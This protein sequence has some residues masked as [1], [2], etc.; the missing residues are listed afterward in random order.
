MLSI[1]SARRCS[2]GI[3][4]VDDAGGD[5]FGAIFADLKPSIR[6]FTQIKIPLSAILL[7]LFIL[8]AIIIL[9]AL[10][11]PL[12]TELEKVIIVQAAMPCAVFPIVLAQHFGGSSDQSVLAIRSE[13]T[14]STQNHIVRMRAE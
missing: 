9:I 8:P 4:D 12:S 6:V 7:R 1:P 5:S 10:L 3:C 13:L 2:F 14:F 11:L